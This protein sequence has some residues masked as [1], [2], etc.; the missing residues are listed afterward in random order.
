MFTGKSEAAKLVNES[1]SAAGGGGA[2]RGVDDND[3][4][5]LMPFAGV[6]SIWFESLVLSLGTMVTSVVVVVAA[7]DEDRDACLE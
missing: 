1:M 4:S 2:V 3:V 6:T 7:F 5:D